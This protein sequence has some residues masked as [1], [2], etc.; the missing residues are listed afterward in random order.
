[1]LILRAVKI[2]FYPFF[3]FSAIAAHLA[4]IRH[5]PWIN[6]LLLSGPVVLAC[7][8]VSACFERLLPY[9]REWNSVDADFKSDFV[10]TNLVFPPLVEGIEFGL[11]RLCGENGVFYPW[12]FWPSHWPLL[13][14]LALALF[15]AEFGFYWVH[16][17]GH[18]WG[19]LWRFHLTHHTSRRLYWMNSARF[20]PVDLLFNFGTYFLPLALLGAPM[21][22]L[23]LLFTLNAATGLL[24]HAN[25]DF[26]AGI[27]NRIFNTAQLHRWH[28]S[29]S[30]KESMANYGKVLS[31]W[32]QVFGTYFFPRD[33]D[34]GPL[35]VE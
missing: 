32:D 33:R 22:I 9:R 31:C 23:A 20:H 13:A 3:V 29:V 4:L 10:L 6:P 2:I 21:T 30:M 14:Q 12:H 24:E 7:V 1:M 16:R 34:V 28:H 27:L 26:E 5:F 19:W 17:W 8:G 25:I 15:L 18:E 11:K 35:G